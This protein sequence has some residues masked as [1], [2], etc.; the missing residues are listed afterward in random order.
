MKPNCGKFILCEWKKNSLS[1]Y[2]GCCHDEISPNNIGIQGPPLKKHQSRE[3]PAPKLNTVVLFWGSPGGKAVN[4][5]P[6]NA[7]DARDT[8]LIPELGRSPWRR[9]WQLTPVF[10]TGKFR[11][12]RSL[13]KSDATERTHTRAI[14][15]IH[16]GEK[17][18]LFLIMETSR[19]SLFNYTPSSVSN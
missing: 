9:A 8:G 4:N 12:Q 14:I 13:A 2:N 18:G 10:L 5:P 3:N 15:W 11:G 1:N 17:M 7:G 19:S 16:F 6:A